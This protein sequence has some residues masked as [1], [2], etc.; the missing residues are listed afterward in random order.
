[1]LG[2]KGLSGAEGG[3]AGAERLTEPEADP[4]QLSQGQVSERRRGGLMI[5]R[6]RAGV[7]TK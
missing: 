1:M 2:P 7:L 3:K 5:T 6:K 4:A